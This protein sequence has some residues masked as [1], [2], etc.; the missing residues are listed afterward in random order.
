MNRLRAKLLASRKSKGEQPVGRYTP[1]F[2][3][4]ELLVVIAIIAILAALLLPA[5]ARGKSKAKQIGCINN[6]RQL[7]IGTTMYVD[8]WGVYPGCMGYGGYI[9]PARLFAEISNS[10]GAFRCPSAPPYSAWDTNLNKTLGL[11]V[12]QGWPTG[13]GYDPW[14]VDPGRSYF[15]FAYNDWGLRAPGQYPQLGLGGNID[16]C[17]SVRG[18]DVKAPSEMIM[19]ADSR[20]YGYLSANL[21]P[22]QNDQTDNAQGQQWPSNRH[23]RRTDIMFADGHAEKAIRNYVIDSKNSDWRSRWNSDHQPHAEYSWS[24]NPNTANQLDPEY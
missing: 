5:L 16:N 18:S 11:T 21:D 24:T 23:N 2:T 22:A 17:P 14:A 13:P 4:I 20:A 1:G 12:T 19:L 8:N 7:G 15:S 10:R 3:L 6:L 9:W